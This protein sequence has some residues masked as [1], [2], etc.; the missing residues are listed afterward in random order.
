MASKVI[1]VVN[2]R[3]G[4][5]KD[6]LCNSLQSKYQIMST[7]AID[8]IKAIARENG[9]NGEKDDKA[10]LFLAELKRVFVKYNNLPTNYLCKVTDEFLNSAN[11]ILFVHIREADQIEQYKQAISP[12]K[13]VTI[14]IKKDL[15]DK[16][17]L[18]GNP[19]DDEVD[20]YEYDYVFENNL[21]LEESIRN[22]HF[23]IEHIL[24]TKNCQK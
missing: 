20:N 16:T 11:E 21:S 22:F 1:I 23:L 8:P 5:G 19:A 3:G 9:W 12:T 2:G 7:S 4:V 24:H 13:C 17:H 18:F 10:R 6:T 15:I 14:L